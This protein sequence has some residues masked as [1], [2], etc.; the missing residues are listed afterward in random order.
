VT[1]RRLK[2]WFLSFRIWRIRTKPGVFYAILFFIVAAWLLW[3]VF[4][5][6]SEADPVY[7]PFY[8]HLRDNTH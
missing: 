3:D 5:A 1:T 7:I 4:F 2:R 6:L 8:T